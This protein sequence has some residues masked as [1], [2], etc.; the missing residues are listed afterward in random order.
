[1][2]A[3]EVARGRRGRWF[4]RRR[5]YR[6]AEAG[7]RG[8]AAVARR[9]WRRWGGH[10]AA[11]RAFALLKDGHAEQAAERREDD[12]HDGAQQREAEYLRQLRAER[13]LLLQLDLALHL[14]R[15]LRVDALKNLQH[16]PVRHVAEHE[17]DRNAD[18][19]V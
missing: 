4:C 13:H 8:R 7:R 12:D 15:H 6:P 5:R 10:R 18:D 1:Y 11:T 16:H 2:V 17:R 14:L 3:A 19:D 9:R